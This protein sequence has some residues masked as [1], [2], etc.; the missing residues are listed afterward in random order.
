MPGY[1]ALHPCP[2]CGK[3]V[4]DPVSPDRDTPAVA[5]AYPEFVFYTESTDT[6]E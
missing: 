3:A 4:P 5:G 1:G 2:A 6:G